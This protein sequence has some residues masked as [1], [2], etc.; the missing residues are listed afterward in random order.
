M[1]F[2]SITENTQEQKKN[3]NEHKCRVS[4]EEKQFTLVLVGH[5]PICRIYIHSHQWP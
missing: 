1:K 3:K 2:L 4:K 5:Q